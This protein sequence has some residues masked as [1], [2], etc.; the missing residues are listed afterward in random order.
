MALD[1]TVSGRGFSVVAAEVKTLAQQ[2][3]DAK[4]DT[5]ASESVRFNLRC[6]A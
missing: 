5:S 3:A 6:R 1:R 4:G 2:I